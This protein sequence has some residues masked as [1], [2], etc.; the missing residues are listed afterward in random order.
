[1]TLI[2]DIEFGL[3]VT[4]DTC[5]L[6]SILGSLWVFVLDLGQKQDRLTE[7]GTGVMSNVASYTEDRITRI[8]TIFD[9]SE[10][11]GGYKLTSVFVTHGQRDARPT[12]TFPAAEHHRPLTSVPTCAI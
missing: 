9:Y 2:F 4:R 8:S 10:P 6:S 3:S 7:G 12:V 1:V 11:V 5:Q